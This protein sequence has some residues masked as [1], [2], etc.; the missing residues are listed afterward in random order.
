MLLSLFSCKK[1][2]DCEEGNFE[3]GQEYGGGIIFHVNDSKTHGLI[4]TKADQS[5]SAAWGCEGINISG[6]DGNGQENTLDIVQQCAELN[7]AAKIANNLVVDSLDDW[8]L[9]SID[10]LSK[11]F[12]N[13]AYVGNMYTEANYWSSTESDD[14][15]AWYVYF[16]T[17]EKRVYYKSNSNF[18]V[19]AIRA[20]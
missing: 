4:V 14:N 1:D 9:P 2:C 18:R 16:N 5:L 12:D 3:I 17:G 15:Q 6:A 10:E 7:I 11:L 8:Y 20:F 19:R 13:K